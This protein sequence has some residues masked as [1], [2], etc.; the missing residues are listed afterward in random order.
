M[1]DVAATERTSASAGETRRQLALQSLA[2]ALIAAVGL[3]QI[4]WGTRIAGNEGPGYDGRLYASLAQDLPE[5]LARGSL[6]AY[7]VQRIVP[8]AILWVALRSLGC[9]ASDDGVQLAFALYNLLL[10]LVS[11]GL[12]WVVADDLDLSAAGRW[13]GFSL[14][15]LNLANLRLPFH[16]S[17]L[18]D[19]TAFVLGALLVLFHLRR[20]NVGLLATLVLGAFTWRSLFLLGSLLFLFPR[21]PLSG[22]PLFPSRLGVNTRLF[23]GLYAAGMVAQSLAPPGPLLGA[24]SLAVPVAYVSSLALGLLDDQEFARSSGYSTGLWRPVVLAI[25]FVAILKLMLGLAPHAGG[26]TQ[27]LLELARGAYPM[28]DFILDGVVRRGVA[29]PATPLINHTRYFGIAVPLALLLWRP[30]CRAS[31]GLGVGMTAFVGAHLLMGVSPESRQL[32]DGFFGF[33]LVVVLA[34]EH[35]NWSRRVLWLTAALGFFASTVWLPVNYPG[36]AESPG[37]FGRAARRLALLLLDRSR[38]AMFLRQTAVV[39][40]LF[41]VLWLASR[42]RPP[43]QPG[44]TGSGDYP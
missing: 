40:V 12:W 16:Y 36:V 22:K 31:H 6:D 42:V 25:A 34:A 19:T 14:L 27:S 28:R 32:I 13:L 35:R 20:N 1:S 21:R 23:L 43:V 8:S 39:S 4:G 26:P 37:V 15:F 17:P 3:V 29:A 5:S 30:V 2:L 18:T 7:S 10:L 11:G 33:V 24:L 41:I 9:S 38:G 44:P